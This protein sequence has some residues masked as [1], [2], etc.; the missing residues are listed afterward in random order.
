MFFQSFF[1]LFQTEVNSTQF[2]TVN[3]YAN[4]QIVLPGTYIGNMAITTIAPN[5]FVITPKQPTVTTTTGLVPSPAFTL[6]VGVQSTPANYLMD[7]STPNLFVWDVNC[8]AN[9]VS[10]SL[11][12]NYALCLFFNQT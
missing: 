1:A 12:P 5:P 11:A 3:L 9:G 8:L 2:S 4:N 6:T 10:C 7:F